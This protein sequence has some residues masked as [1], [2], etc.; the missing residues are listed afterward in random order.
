MQVV[1]VG[2]HDIFPKTI[3]CHGNVP[4]Q[5][6]KQGR[7]ISSALKALSYGEKIVKIGPVYPEIFE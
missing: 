5:I 3:D 2:V 7:F 1:S 4:R 6:G